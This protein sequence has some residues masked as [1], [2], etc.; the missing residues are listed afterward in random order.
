[1]SL[2]WSKFF[3]SDW[4]S[5]PALRLCSYAAQGLWM[6]MLCIAAVHDPIGYVAVAGRALDPTAIARMTGGSEGE[7]QILLDE[8]ARNGVFSSDR[9]GRIYSRRM[10][11]DARKSAEARKNGKKG[12]NPNLSPQR[13][14]SPPV[15]PSVKGGLKPHKLEARIPEENKD[16]NAS[17]VVSAEPKPTADDVRIA[18]EEWNVLAARLGLPSARKLDD[19]RRR[20]IKTR[21][22]DGG[23]DGWREALAAVQASEHCRGDNDRQWKAD[24]DFVCTA[25][26]YRR[27]REGFYGAPDGPA[28]T[29]AGPIKSTGPPVV[30]DDA[31][32]AER[33]ARIFADEKVKP[34]ESSH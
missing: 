30:K 13:E 19:G 1:M 31:Y 12:G 20:A 2:P 25:S 24:L 9:N 23:L 7:V 3:W 21:L 28:Y 33:R 11:R 27:L 10:V 32:W 6:R 16:A 17:S 34:A 22:A 14:I 29:P 18:F 4:D 15:N 8:L 26:K 5:D